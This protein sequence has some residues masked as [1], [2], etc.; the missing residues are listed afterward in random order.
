MAED[1]GLLTH[2]RVL[3]IS[4]VS[5][6]EGLVQDLALQRFIQ[7]AAAKQLTKVDFCVPRKDVDR[8]RVLVHPTYASLAPTTTVIEMQFCSE[9]DA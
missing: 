7:Q 3:R 2:L 8:L 5:G 9:W 6:V 4:N 1:D